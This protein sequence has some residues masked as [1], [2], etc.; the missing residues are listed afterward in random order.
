MF[1]TGVNHYGAQSIMPATG[2]DPTALNSWKKED[3]AFRPQHPGGV[4]SRL[5]QRFDRCDSMV[6]RYGG[7]YYMYYTGRDGWAHD[8]YPDGEDW[9]TSYVLGNRQAIGVTPLRWNERIE[10]P[11]PGIGWRFLSPSIATVVDD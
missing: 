3:I 4:Y 6:I 7:H 8:F 2:R 5:K 11:S 9:Y 1:Y 10:S